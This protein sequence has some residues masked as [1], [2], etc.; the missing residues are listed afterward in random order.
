MN[1]SVLGEGNCYLSSLNA[2]P[3]LISFPGNMQLIQ[4]KCHKKSRERTN[5]DDTATK[6]FQVEA[7]KGFKN[8]P[9][10]GFPISMSVK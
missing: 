6:G 10:S 9:L 8:V 5:R 1:I 3:A 7:T 2:A 4:D